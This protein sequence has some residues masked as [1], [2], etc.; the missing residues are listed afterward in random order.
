VLLI[1][2]GLLKLNAG[3]PALPFCPES[4]PLPPP[5]RINPLLT[6]VK[7][8]PA[9]PPVIF[10]PGVVGAVAVFDVLQYKYTPL[11]IVTVMSDTPAT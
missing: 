6:I 3:P 5:P 1:V 7:V 4:P 9:V 11:L 10:N 2:A 8:S